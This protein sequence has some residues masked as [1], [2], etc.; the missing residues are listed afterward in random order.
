VGESK[1]CLTINV[2]Y[3]LHFG[4]GLFEPLLRTLQIIFSEREISQHR[5]A[6]DELKLVLAW[7]FLQR[8]RLIQHLPGIFIVAMGKINRCKIH[9]CRLIHWNQLRGRLE[10]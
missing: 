10:M 3:A 8:G 2:V 5:E 1:E 6:S 9:E 4:D 7:R